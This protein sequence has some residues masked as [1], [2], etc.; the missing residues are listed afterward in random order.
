[1][2]LAS[3]GQVA[4]LPVQFSA[5]SQTPP[6]ARQVVLLGTNALAGQFLLTPSQSSVISQSPADT[7]Q[8]VP[9]GSTRS[10]GQFGLP[11]VQF[12][13]WSQISPPETA[14]HTVLGGRKASAGQAPLTPL[15]FS[16]ASQSPAVPRHSVPLL[17][18]VQFALQ[19]DPAVPLFTPS[20]HCSVTH[21]LPSM[22]PLPQVLWNATD[23]KWP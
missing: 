6:E 19:H 17:F 22:M 5:G 18:S 23:T 8:V 13:A 16:A 15:Q 10:A 4:V 1:V 20:S 11:P 12:S 2:L 21:S 14:R 9:F 3:A 7:R